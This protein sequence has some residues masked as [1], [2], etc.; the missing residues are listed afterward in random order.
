MGRAG[1]VHARDGGG[2]RLELDTLK[3]NEKM[4]MVMQRYR[5]DYSTPQDDGSVLWHAKWIGGPSL[6]RIENCRLDLA[7]DMRRTVYITGD[8]DTWF[9]QPAICK[10][11]NCRVKGYVTC[12]DDGTLFFHCQRP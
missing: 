4:E 12:D 8:P 10:I 7:G 11:Q 3:R 5:A 6:A 2:F 9:S 1:R